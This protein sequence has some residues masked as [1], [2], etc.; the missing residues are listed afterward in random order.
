[1]RRRT[2]AGALLVAAELAIEILGS[3][4]ANDFPLAFALCIVVGAAALV[5]LPLWL[6]RDDIHRWTGN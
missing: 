4:A 3:I 5:L 6:L 1:L 2:V